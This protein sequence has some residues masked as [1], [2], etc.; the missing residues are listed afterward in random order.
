MLRGVGWIQLWRIVA[1]WVGGR[2]RTPD[3]TMQLLRSPCLVHTS[4]SELHIQ[5]P[6]SRLEE[7][8]NI[9]PSRL[10]QP[11]SLSTEARSTEKP[12]EMQPSTNLEARTEQLDR[13]PTVIC[14]PEDLGGST[15]KTLQRKTPTLPTTTYGLALGCTVN[16]RDDSRQPTTPKMKRMKAGKK[17]R[18]N[19]KHEGTVEI[20]NRAKGRKEPNSR[21]KEPN[22]DGRAKTKEEL[23]SRRTLPTRKHEA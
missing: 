20:L 22:I 2:G 6:G 14:N 18:S 8:S 12:K 3:G 23:Q 7:P 21:T 1:W 17:R 16:Y 4:S 5:L 15:Q 19:C 13:T 9:S 10:G 11:I